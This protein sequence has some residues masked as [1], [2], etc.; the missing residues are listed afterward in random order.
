MGW[1]NHTDACYYNRLD[2]SIGDPLWGGN[3]PANGFMY[4]VHC[5]QGA[6]AGWVLERFRYL[7]R[8]PPGYGGLPSPLSLALQ[9]INRL[10][11]TGPDIGLAPDPAGSG[12]VGLPVW[13]W[14][15]V[16]AATWGPS[17][18]TASVPGLSVTATARADHIIW[19]MG[20]G[21]VITCGSPGAAYQTSYGDSA[22]PNC[23]HK[24]LQPS[25]GQ[26]SGRYQITATT[27]WTVTWSGGG[28]SG[29]VAINRSSSTSLRINE[30]QVVIG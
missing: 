21:T 17:S 16:S 1:F 23:G 29:T 13:M 22:S 18:A 14:T 28:R 7:T 25:R 10:P 15:R 24:Y 8:S 27:R 30:L 19:S 11:I 5:W 2:L 4:A 6:S 26:T 9:A 3:D 20:D 12:L